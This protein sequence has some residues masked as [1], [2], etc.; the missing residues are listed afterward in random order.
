[1]AEN[2]GAVRPNRHRTTFNAFCDTHEKAWTGIARARLCDDALAR[3]VVARMKG[4]L[5]SQWSWVIRQ[6]VPAF[7]AWAMVKE[8]I[9]AALAVQLLE[10]EQRPPE[11]V[12]TWVEAVRWGLEGFK[13]LTD[14][15]GDGVHRELYIAIRGLS[16]RRHD[17]VVLSFFL[18]L[19]DSLI[20]E[21]LNTTEANVR[22]T[23]SQALARLAA[24][25]RGKRGQQ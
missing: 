1:M 15:E 8:A 24:K 22:V 17:V 13:T 10:A 5:W 20:A 25:L 14:D 11:S 23:R 7:H 9:G 4:R 3:D 16:E 18:E 6:E 12:P 19:S 21:Y 2:E